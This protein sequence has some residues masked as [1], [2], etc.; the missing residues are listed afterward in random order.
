MRDGTGKINNYKTPFP[1]PSGHVWGVSVSVGV[2]NYT[3]TRVVC[4]T[5]YMQPFHQQGI[6]E[7]LWIT[8]F[9][10]SLSSFIWGKGDQNCL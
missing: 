3:N 8:G 7:K 5:V 4:S 2:Y 6:K 1:Y 9:M 10:I